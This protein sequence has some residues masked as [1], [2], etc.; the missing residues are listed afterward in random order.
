MEAYDK[1]GAPIHRGI[2]R[3]IVRIHYACGTCGKK[4]DVAR[5]AG[6]EDRITETEPTE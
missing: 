2:D 3:N 4:W 5:Q 6:Q 1:H